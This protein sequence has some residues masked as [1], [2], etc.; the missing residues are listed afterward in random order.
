MSFLKRNLSSKENCQ[1]RNI[2]LIDHQILRTDIE[3]CVQPSIKR[4]H[5]SNLRLK[6][7]TSSSLFCTSQKPGVG[8]RTLNLCLLLNFS[9]NSLYYPNELK[10][11]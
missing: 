6:W 7:L 8:N 10:Q 4:M 1:Q 5:I 9:E 2:V 3:T 11:M